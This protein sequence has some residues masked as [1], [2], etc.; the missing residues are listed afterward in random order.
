MAKGVP[1]LRKAAEQGSPRAQ[2]ELADLYHFGDGGLYL[3]GMEGALRAYE[4]ILRRHA[5]ERSTWLDSLLEKR[6]RGDLPDTVRQ[7]IAD[8]RCK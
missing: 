8:R 3:A 7:L 4:S 1:W 2:V 5:S 6:N